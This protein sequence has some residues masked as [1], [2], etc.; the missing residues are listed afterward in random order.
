MRFHSQ[1]AK[2][3]KA[4][5]SCWTLE[6]AGHSLSQWFLLQ[7]QRGRFSLSIFFELVAGLSCFAAVKADDFPLRLCFTDFIIRD[8][9]LAICSIL[10][11]HLI[12]SSFLC[13]ESVKNPLVFWILIVDSTDSAVLILRVRFFVLSRSCPL[14]RRM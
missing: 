9:F 10:F 2:S 14:C 8:D 7:N 4:F 13:T 3:Y 11:W 1:K 6:Y 5:N 12:T